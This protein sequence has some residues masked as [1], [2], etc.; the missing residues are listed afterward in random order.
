MMPFMNHSKRTRAT[1]PRTTPRTT[2]R[3][4]ALTTMAA[5]AVAVTVAVTGTTA[6]FAAGDG[7]GRGT[8]RGDRAARIAA[9]CADPDAAMARLEARRLGLDGR[10]AA[11]TEWRAT[12][13]ASGWTRLVTGIDSRID[14]L[15]TRLDR[16]S[17]R[18]TAAPDWIAEHCS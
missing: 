13:D 9:I 16:T 17:D 3:T 11:L 6:A 2:R 14:R 8:D 1:T 12:A 15:Q 18:L 5:V 10:I 4:T 7:D